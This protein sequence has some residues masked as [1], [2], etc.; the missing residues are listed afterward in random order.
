LELALY[1]AA[2]ASAEELKD[3]LLSSLINFTTEQFAGKNNF[4]LL[5]PTNAGALLGASEMHLTLAL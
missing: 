2:V 3:T 5:F 4:E 1:P